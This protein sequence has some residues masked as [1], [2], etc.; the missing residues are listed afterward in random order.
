MNIKFLDN[1]LRT[2]ASGISNI[3]GIID[4]FVGIFIFS[5]Q[6]NNQINFILYSA[7]TYI[8]ISFGLNKMY[9]SYRSKSLKEIIFELLTNQVIIFIFLFIFNFFI[10]YKSIFN[11]YLFASKIIIFS[12]PDKLLSNL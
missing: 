2:N 11:I 6:I 10:S 5:Y 8:L 9:G 3:H 7:L 1:K 4:A 12:L